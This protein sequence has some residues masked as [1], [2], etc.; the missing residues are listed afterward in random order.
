MIRI[1]KRT[2][3]ELRSDNRYSSLIE[4]SSVFGTPCWV[5]LS[6]RHSPVGRIAQT[7]ALV[8]EVEGV[9]RAWLIGCE[10]HLLGLDAFLSPLP[11]T[12][13]QYS[14]LAVV[15]SPGDAKSLIL[16]LLRHLNERYDLAFVITPPGYVIDEEEMQ[17]RCRILT[18]KALIIDLAKNNE[19]LWR[20]IKKTRRAEIRKAKRSN[21][22][23][24][25]ENDA[26]R[27]SAY[28][29]LLRGFS[30]QKGWTLPMT[31]PFFHDLMRS[32]HER[33]FV[34]CTS[35]DGEMLAGAI[36]LVHSQVLYFYSAVT[37]VKG[38]RLGAGS[39]ILWAIIEWGKQNGMR[40][41]D[42]VGGNIPHVAAFKRSFGAIEESYSMGFVTRHP[43]LSSCVPSLIRFASNLGLL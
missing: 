17:C 39:L 31:E 41:C 26:R 21:L 9:P 20:G 3:D 24:V 8:L 19:E 22:V 38:R 12:M 42:L 4:S 5:E 33:A 43:A 27:V 2:L 32:M 1:E 34:V 25:F 36:V 15:G 23:T 28:Y 14:G 37:T 10:F 18:R 16:K 29:K 40:L 13:A 6:V 11:R 30:E 7:V 35:H